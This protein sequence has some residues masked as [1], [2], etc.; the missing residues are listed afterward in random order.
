MDFAELAAQDGRQT[1]PQA[2]CKLASISWL[3]YDIFLTFGDEVEYIWKRRWSLTKALYLLTR[4]TTFAIILYSVVANMRLDVSDAEC[5]FVFIFE[6]AGTFWI[7]L[8]VQA[9]IQYRIYMM[10]GKD[11]TIKWLNIGLWVVEFAALAVL[12]VFVLP[13]G[14]SGEVEDALGSV[15]NRGAPGG[16]LYIAIPA[17]LY[18]SWLLALVLRRGV[19]EYKRHSNGKALDTASIVFI[20]IRDNIVYYVLMIGSILVFIIIIRI[21]PVSPG[22]AAISFAHSATAIGACRIVLNSLRAADAPT[23]GNSGAYPTQPTM[24]FQ[25]RTS[26]TMLDEDAHER[27]VDYVEM[28]DLSASSPETSRREAERQQLAS[29]RSGLT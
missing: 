3:V 18:E 24:V 7:L 28:D 29:S 15:C 6:P 22:E 17:V 11:R 9:I 4:Y 14:H 23:P 12:A 1:T 21:A 27:G 2:F 19:Q 20:V 5:R 26:E 13:H 10:Y 8:L 16:I 25:R